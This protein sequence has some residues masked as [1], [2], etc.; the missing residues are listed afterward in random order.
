MLDFLLAIAIALLADNDD[1][2]ALRDSAPAY[3]TLDTAREHI[4]AARMAA[5]RYGVDV[6]LVLS[7]AY[8]ESRYQPTAFGREHHGLFSCGLMGVGPVQACDQAELTIIDGYLAG[9]RTLRNW[10]D[11]ARRARHHPANDRAGRIIAD[12]VDKL[13]RPQCAMLGY[14][15]GWDLIEV[16]TNGQHPNC[17]IPNQRFGRAALIGRRKVAATPSVP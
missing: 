9:A 4:G 15:G 6:N 13:P 14:A 1:V 16:C 7:I 12:C 11:T 2:A 17:E 10:M 5:D 8:F 3:L